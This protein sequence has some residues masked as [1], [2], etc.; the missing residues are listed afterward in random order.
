LDE[1]VWSVSSP[2]YEAFVALEDISVMYTFSDAYGGPWWRVK[3]RQGGE[4]DL[5]NQH[6][7]ELLAAWLTWRKR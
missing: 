3:L 2:Q 1:N 7:L 5:N 6:G 4:F